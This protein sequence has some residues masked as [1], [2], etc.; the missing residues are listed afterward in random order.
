ML[1]RWS[2]YL[3]IACFCL[4]SLA[5]LHMTQRPLCIDSKVVERIDRITDSGTESLYRCALNKATPYNTYFADK[6]RDLSYRVLRIE[7]VLESLEPFYKK[8]QITILSDRPLL[9]RVQGH[10]LYIGEALLDAPGHLEKALAKIWYR[11][12]NDNSFDQQDITEEV[13]TDL[14][15]SL[16]S[17]DVDIGDPQ[18]RVLTALRKVKWPYVIKSIRAYCESPWKRS[19]HYAIC[20]NAIEGDKDF[21]QEVVQMS[22]RPM[23]TASLVKSYRKLSGADRYNFTM[24]LP[25]FL[26]QENIAP[27]KTVVADQTVLQKAAEIIRNVNLFVSNPV[28]L[29]T[30]EVHRSFVTNFRNELRANGYSEAFVEASFDVLYVSHEPL[31]GDEPVF[32]DLMKQS[33][34][35]PQLQIALR[36]KEKIWMLPSKYP[37]ALASFGQIKA[38]KTI[39]EKCGEYNFSFVMEYAE[40]TEKLLIV[41]RCAAQKTVVYNDY[42]D[43]GTEAFA[44]ANKGIAFVQFHVPSLLMKKS[45]LQAAGNVFDFIQKRD[46]DNP[47]FKGLGWQEVRWDEH[48]SAY[49]PKAYVDAIEW[50]RVPVTSTSL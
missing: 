32:K 14:L 18:T 22:M 1:A 48:A 44:Q 16:E 4:L 41:D 2:T 7:R 37:M 12:R 25:R 30:S 10:H 21:T 19:E 31:T 35:N 34:R 28:A 47:S 29:K 50:F 33:Q 23:L 42:L 8:A 17:G 45:D 6:L 27:E 5:V 49:Q 13:M 26:R 38:N 46:V 3:S 24:Q 43:K 40:S 15:V 9:F 36:D 20:V 39:I 11:E